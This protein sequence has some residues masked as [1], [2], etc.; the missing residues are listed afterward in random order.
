MSEQSTGSQALDAD[1]ITTEVIR[2]GLLSA[3][4]L[5]RQT[6]VRTAFSPAIYEALDFA[7]GLYDKNIRLLAEAPTLPI[8]MGTMSFCIEEAL[9]SVGG[10]EVLEEGDVILYNVPYGTGSHP[11][12]TAVVMPV[13]YEGELIGYSA[14][15][16]HL[17]DIAGKE[18]YS[19]N[20]LD[21]FQEGTVYP[22]VRL[23]RRG[24]LVDDVYR[25]VIANSRTPVD[26]AGDLGAE[27]AG[28]RTA[29]KALCA[30]VE[31]HGL[32]TFRVCVE[33]M[34]DHGER[35]VRDYLSAIPNGR[36]VG[37]GVMD[38]NGVETDLVPFEVSVEVDGSDVRIDYSAAPPQ[39]IG[40]IN[41]P[42][43]STVSAARV[44]MAMLAGNGEPPNEGH[45]RPLEV[46]TRPG[47]LFHPIAPAPCF[48]YG[49]PADQSIEVIFGAL[50]SAL[51]EAVPAHSGGDVCAL[52]WW[53]KDAVTGET[54]TDGAAHPVGQGAF[55][56]GDGVSANFHHSEAG[57][58]LPSTEVWEQKNPWIVEQ[59]AFA[60]DSC[61]AG[62]TRGGLGLD[63][64]FRL[65]E[66]CLVTSALERTRTAPWGLLGGK[67]GRPNDLIVTAPDGTSQHYGKITGLKIEAGSLVE[68]RTG[69]GG[70]Y[71]E[72]AERDVASIVRDYSL[73]FLTVEAIERDYPHAVSELETHITA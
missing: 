15:K 71:G 67:E 32:E 52:V 24:V 36:Y 43:P 7:A 55:A 29:A 23:Y 34:F 6:I 1:P 50:A 12:D 25:F 42:L 38:D 4:R 3:A 35:V 66:D 62:R 68:L 20:T 53:G 63:I 64:H 73:G 14:A 58:A 48:L 2:Q 10:A 70:G 40:P 60:P 28:I 19:T 5:L 51:P 8:F 45:F 22:G 47:T 69:G 39:Q 27:V 11:Q 65:L 31:R 17:T 41:C 21:V 13:F 16:G 46:L 49:W 9:A 59:L 57:A 33:R 26:V 18:P 56:H 44:A 37:H 30:L 72:P 54:W 61:G